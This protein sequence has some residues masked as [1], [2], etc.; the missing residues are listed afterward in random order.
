LSG[1]EMQ[2]LAIARAIL[3]DPK[4]LIMDEATSNL[5]AVSERLVTDALDR[6]MPGRTTL[7]IA[8]RLTTASRATRI[9]VLRRGEIVEIGSHEE[10]MAKGLVYAG[11]YKAFLSGVLGEELG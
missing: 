8:H 1:G 11:M 9:A 10:L 4:I 6:F 3:R 2:R 7:F 5:D